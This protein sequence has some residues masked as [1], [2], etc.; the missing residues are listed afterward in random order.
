MDSFI[1]VNRATGRNK[2][3][4][5]VRFKSE[6]EAIKVINFAIGRSWGGRKICAHFAR[7]REQ[8]QGSLALIHGSGRRN[9][10]HGAKAG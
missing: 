6:A 2:G 10:L 7:T 1:P 8:K 5:F 4:G 9:L 3:F